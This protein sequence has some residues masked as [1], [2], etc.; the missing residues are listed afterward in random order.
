[1]HLSLKAAPWA[2]Q[3]FLTS[4]FLLQSIFSLATILKC[5]NFCSKKDM[6]KP[7]KTT[8]F[9]AITF[10]LVWSNQKFPELWVE[11]YF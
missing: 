7:L 3:T 10:V 8:A 6:D 11:V 5:H 9:Q 4:V 1:M 2:G